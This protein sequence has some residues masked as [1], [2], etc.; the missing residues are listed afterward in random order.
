MLKIFMDTKKQRKFKAYGRKLEPGAL[1][2]VKKV[3][4]GV[5]LCESQKTAMGSPVI[6]PVAQMKSD[7]VFILLDYNPEFPNFR[8]VIFKG[9][10]F[11]CLN[12]DISRYC[13]KVS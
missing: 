9:K 12:A 5:S 2:S 1:L 3:P 4:F 11:F 13:E 7:D 6:I 10:R 8:F